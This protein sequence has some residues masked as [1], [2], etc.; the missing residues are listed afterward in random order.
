MHKKSTKN[1][2]QTSIVKLGLVILILFAN[3][4]NDY[5]DIIEDIYQV[6]QF[7]EMWMKV[8]LDICISLFHMGNSH[9]SDFCLNIFKKMSRFISKQGVDVLI[10]FIKS[11]EKTNGK[12]EEKEEE[13]EEDM[14]N[15]DEEEDKN[16]FDGLDEE[17]IEM[18]N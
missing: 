10:D 7:D 9:L 6:T 16:M 12:K 1:D 11:D 3:R 14:E 8:Y 5:A 13:M 18:K 2:K 15:E 4:P 17:D